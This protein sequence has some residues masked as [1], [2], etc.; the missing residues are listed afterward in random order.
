MAK[1]LSNVLAKNTGANSR[2]AEGVMGSIRRGLAAQK[3]ANRTGANPVR[4][5][6]KKTM[7]LQPSWEEA[8]EKYVMPP[9]EKKLPP[10]FEKLLPNWEESYEKH[11]SEKTPITK[12][13][14]MRNAIT[15]LLAAFGMEE[16]KPPFGISTRPTKTRKHGRKPTPGVT[17]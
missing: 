1:T 3:M 8:Y 16:K 14:L 13:T 4:N 15:N 10:P 2:A 17:Y 5:V 12:E 6:A 11:M 9:S 7:P